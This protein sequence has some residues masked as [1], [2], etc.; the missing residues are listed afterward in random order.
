MVD[1]REYIRNILFQ[2]NLSLSELSK[3]LGYKSRTSLDRILNANTR[4]ES[5]RKLEQALLKAFSLTSDEKR[6][7]HEAVQVTIY[8]KERYLATQKM[9]D[10]VQGVQSAQEE[11]LTIVDGQSGCT[12]DLYHRYAEG[13]SVHMIVVNC[14]YIAGLFALMKKLLQRED[15][16]VAHYMYVNKDN[17][18]TISAVNSL[19]TV[20][21]ERGYDGYV[22]HGESSGKGGLD[23]GLNEADMLI[24]MWR[25]ADETERMDMVLFSDSASEVLIEAKCPGKNF[26]ERTGLDRRY[27]TSIKRT[28][29]ECSA[30]EDY[31]QYSSDYA[32]LERNHAVWKIKPDV[33]VDQ[34][35]AW[36]LK[37]AIQDGPIPQDEQFSQTLDILT[38]IYQKRVENTYSK[39]KHSFIIYKRGAMHRFA[40]TGKTTDHF[41]GMRPYTPK[42]RI[43]ILSELL[44]HQL[45]NPY[46]HLYFLKDDAALR[47]AEI[48][49]YED[50][51]MLI[52]ES[53]TD[54][55]LEEGHSE[56]MIT[57][58]EMLRLYKKFYMEVLIRD[59]V[60]PES[61]TCS[62]LRNL[63]EMVRQ[64][65]H[66]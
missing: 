22:R 12:V 37:K 45:E 57:H 18:R 26:L 50:I 39:R 62:G 3:I 33:G 24:T 41:W 47:N 38:E 6:A 5:I 29:F 27:Y 15:M 16:A 20:F 40:M 31:I 52:L 59:C 9:W 13:G 35:P 34:I 46:V 56:I 65:D 43:A 36:I 63:I 66:H 23:C 7:L 61:E 49:Y 64:L 53:D 32:A 14:Q 51:G 54:Y 30:F 11:D 8:G 44:K 4:P 19:M 28:Y 21:Y 1:V 42:E 55:N 25:D 58:Q 2:E 48:A 10:F 17:V 60:Y